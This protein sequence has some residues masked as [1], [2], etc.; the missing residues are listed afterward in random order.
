MLCTYAVMDNEAVPIGA[1]HDL[2]S[3]LG[4]EESGGRWFMIE[5]RRPNA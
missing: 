1:G 2:E 3:L 4:L 5:V